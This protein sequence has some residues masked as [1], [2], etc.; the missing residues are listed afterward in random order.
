MD[1]GEREGERGEEGKKGKV[2][3]TEEGRQRRSGLRSRNWFWKR[4]RR[5]KE[6]KGVVVGGGENPCSL[7]PLSS[8]SVISPLPLLLPPALAELMWLGCGALG[9]QNFED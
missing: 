7:S 4:R 3:K 5:K 8:P 9:C 2:G 1:R 6:I